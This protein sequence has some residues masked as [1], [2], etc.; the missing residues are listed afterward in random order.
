MQNPLAESGAHHAERV[1]RR[2]TP[3][4][5]RGPYL[6]AVRDAW[7]LARDAGDP[8]H[9]ALALAMAAYA[10]DGRARGVGVSTLLRALDTVVRPPYGEN[11]GL[12][13]GGAREWAGT[14]L[15]RSYYQAD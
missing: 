13:F 8:H 14:M 2:R 1:E 11:P 5:A 7:Q 4:A 9:P 12:D 10:R 6:L 3:S 15:I